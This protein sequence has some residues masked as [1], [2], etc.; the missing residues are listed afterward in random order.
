[1]E[2]SDVLR[3]S[4]CSLVVK[5]TQG[6]VSLYYKKGVRD[7]EYLFNHEPA[8]LQGAEVADKVIGKAAAGYMALAGVRYAYADVLSRKALPL[9]KQAGVDY[10]Y[11]QLVD[12]V[13]IPDGDNRC[14]LEQ[15]VEPA[16][17]A[18]ETVDLLQAHFRLMNF[19]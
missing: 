4:G 13:V 17:T 10:S 12:A 7:L 15:I 19:K 18:I 2:L 16:R 14:P 6:I 9:L 8:K 5:D 1:M 11:G 3:Q